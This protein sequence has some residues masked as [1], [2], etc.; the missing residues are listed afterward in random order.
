MRKFKKNLLSPTDSAVPEI[1]RCCDTG[2]DRDKAIAEFNDLELKLHK[3]SC[4]LVEMLLAVFFM[5]AEADQIY[6]SEVNMRNP[7]DLLK[8]LR[9]T[10][11]ELHLNDV[12]IGV[13][14]RKFLDEVRY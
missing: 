10:G 9:D 7:S 4:D 3:S 11:K 8:V 5:A 1:Y 13:E 12:Q 6:V 14:I 2:C